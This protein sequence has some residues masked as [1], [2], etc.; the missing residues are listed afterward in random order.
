[1]ERVSY[2][3]PL[4]LPKDLKPSDPNADAK[5]AIFLVPMIL[6]TDAADHI[7]TNR[8]TGYGYGS[9]KVMTTDIR[10]GI[11]GATGGNTCD[12]VASIVSDLCTLPSPVM[13][14]M[15][16]PFCALVSVGKET[17]QNN[18]ARQNF[19][20]T[21]TIATSV[22]GMFRKRNVCAPPKQNT[23]ASGDIFKVPDQWGSSRS[24]LDPRKY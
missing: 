8:E 18:A 6:Y 17:S 19:S 13:G 4:I 1:M 10:V 21:K 9:E 14:N 20:P 15:Q 3:H 7:V 12:V 24:F 22:P 2:G 11:A 16:S 23:R 5:E